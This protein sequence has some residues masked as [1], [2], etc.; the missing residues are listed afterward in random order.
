MSTCLLCHNYFEEVDSWSTL[1]SLTEPDPLCSTCSEKFEKVDGETCEICGR[2]FSELSDEYREG[3]L[4][5]DCVRWEKEAEWQ[6]VLTKNRSIYL[7]NDFAKEVISLYKFRGDYVISSIFKTP[8]K[9]AFKTH[10][11]SSY[12]VV[13]IP[14]SDE[15]LYERGFNQA[16]AL[17]ELLDVQ[18]HEVLARTHL[19]KQSKKSR[20]ER[21][22][23]GNVFRVIDIV[24]DK[25]ILL[26]DDI[27]TTGSTLRHA[28]TMLLEAGAK[29]VSS[30]TL[31]RG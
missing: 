23:R 16:K 25:D 31:I 6:G 12:L 13:P 24:K 5:Y 26:V 3:N 7:Y 28:A 2:P 8:L 14:L 21:I 17:A 15:R 10:F 30:L 22:S 1:F 4:C 19:E 11:N 18:V 20:K 9:K 27:Y 29:S